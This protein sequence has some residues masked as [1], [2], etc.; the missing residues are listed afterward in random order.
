MYSDIKTVMRLKKNSYSF[1]RIYFKTYILIQL[2][3]A[4]GWWQK[5]NVSY[6]FFFHLQNTIL[7]GNEKNTTRIDPILLLYL[8][9]SIKTIHPPL[10][11]SRSIGIIVLNT[12]F[13]VFHFSKSYWFII[14]VWRNHFLNQAQNNCIKSFTI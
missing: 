6:Y 5:A 8:K 7:L 14:F 10:V 3:K 2:F 9:I 12:N 13:V 4:I 1:Q 11:F